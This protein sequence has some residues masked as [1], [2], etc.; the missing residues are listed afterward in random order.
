M[1]FE[2]DVERCRIEVDHVCAFGLRR[3]QHRPIESFDPTC[4]ERH[5]AGVKV[6]VPPSQAEQ[7]GA[8]RSGDGGE[9]Q[10]RVQV[11][12]TGRDLLEK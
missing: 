6:D 2:E 10:Q 7:L 9:H 3:C 4:A 1:S 8:S 12:I 5:P 11:R